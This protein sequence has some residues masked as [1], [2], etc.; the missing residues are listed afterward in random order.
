MSASSVPSS[1]QCKSWGGVRVRRGYPA[2]TVTPSSSSMYST[3]ALDIVSFEEALL[4]LRHECFVLVF[5]KALSLPNWPSA[6][7]LFQP[8][9]IS[10]ITPAHVHRAADF[11]NLGCAAINL[12]LAVPVPPLHSQN[13][14]IIVINVIAFHPQ[15]LPGEQEFGLVVKS[16]GFQIKE[17]RV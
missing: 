13:A 14:H 11:M 10:S 16:R 15:Q 9:R 17:R 4:L 8:G 1:F 3:V 6:L 5:S 2:F 7:Q 12:F